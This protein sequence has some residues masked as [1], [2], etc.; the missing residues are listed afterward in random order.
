MTFQIHAIPTADLTLIRATA[1][2][3]ITAEGGE[4]ARCCLRDAV[5]GD[6]L[7]L[8]NYEPPLPEGT[9]YRETGAVFVHA[10]PCAGPESTDRYP[11]D[12]HRRPQVLRAYDARGW[13]H[14]ATTVH[15]GTD[16][17][18]AIVKQLA[19]P[20]VAWIHSRNVAYGCYMF[21]ITAA[22]GR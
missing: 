17:E 11:S 13:I 14:P 21:T 18:S 1:T 9:P 16:P 22:G 19:E 15:D 12:W 4:P 3:Q 20:G 10:E 8:A 5:A 6:D 2:E 7:L